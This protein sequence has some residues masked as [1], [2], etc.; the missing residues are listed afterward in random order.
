MI[1]TFLDKSPGVRD[2]SGKV[3]GI[4]SIADMELSDKE[5]LEVELTSLQTANNLV[6]VAEALHDSSI[7]KVSPG[8]KD[9][10]TQTAGKSYP[11]D[12]SRN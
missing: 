3:T 8:W 7:I 2:V 6:V 12:L 10:P 1:D 9:P 4:D 5:W 11:I